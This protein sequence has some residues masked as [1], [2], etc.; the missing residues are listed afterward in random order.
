MKCTVPVYDGRDKFKLGNYWD[1]TY[2]GPVK[3]DSAVM[4]LFSI[5][6]GSLP[7]RM[8]DRNDLPHGI[9]FAIYF[10][11]LAIIVLAEPKERFSFKASDEEPPAF[12]VKSIETDLPEDEV[13]EVDETNEPFL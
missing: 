8:Q 12:G 11:I 13:H 4:L 1:K 9:D 5:K 6:K 10:N 7:K 2:P 3:K